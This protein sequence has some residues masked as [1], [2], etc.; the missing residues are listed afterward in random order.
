MNLLAWVIASTTH[1]G[2]IY[3]D[4]PVS[5]AFNQGGYLE[6]NVKVLSN[7]YRIN[8]DSLVWYHND[9]QIISEGRHVISDNNTRLTINNL[10]DYDAGVYKVNFTYSCDYPLPSTADFV[11]VIF[12]VQEHSLSNYSPLTTVPTYY[13]TDRNSWPGILLNT[14]V[15]LQY[16]DEIYYDF[17]YKDGV[18]VPDSNTSTT[19]QNGLRTDTLELTGTESDSAAGIYMVILYAEYDYHSS[20]Y[21]S[22][23]FVARRIYSLHVYSAIAFSVWNVKSHCELLSKIGGTHITQSG[24][25]PMSYF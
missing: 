22:N 21:D 17:W 9:S 15:P 23:C 13:I 7:Y 1:A 24:K 12:T 14:S 16:I 5:R 19:E 8:N 6:M 2:L 20:L 3:T 25:T 10:R 4:E 11:P 18:R